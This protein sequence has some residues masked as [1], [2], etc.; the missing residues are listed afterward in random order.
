VPAE[1]NLAANQTRGG[2]PYVLSQGTG[3]VVMYSPLAYAAGHVTMNVDEG[4]GSPLL[5]FGHGMTGTPKSISHLPAQVGFTFTM[6]DG[7]RACLPY[8]GDGFAGTVTGWDTF[9]TVVDPGMD[10][11]VVYSVL[12]IEDGSGAN[13]GGGSYF[14]GRDGGSFEQ[15]LFNFVNLD[16]LF[17]KN[18]SKLTPGVMYDA[19]LVAE[20][21]NGQS[22]YT[23]SG[24]VAE[25]PNAISEWTYRLMLENENVEMTGNV[26]LTISPTPMGG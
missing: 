8:R 22:K 17:Q 12:S 9:Y 13:I 6:N 26:T 3:V 14:L 15:Y 25:L 23:F 2:N 1:S 7:T 20:T 11:E 18:V 4:K 10:P 5:I 21:A 24:T 16:T 19:V